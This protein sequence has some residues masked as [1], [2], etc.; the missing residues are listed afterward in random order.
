MCALVPSVAYLETIFWAALLLGAPTL[1]L[2]D[3]GPRASPAVLAGHRPLPGA[4]AA[5]TPATPR[6]A[7]PGPWRTHEPQTLG[8]LGRMDG[9]PHGS[10]PLRR[11]GN[12]GNGARQRA[13]GRDP[14]HRA[15]DVLGERRGGR[16]AQDAGRRAGLSSACSPPW[17]SPRIRLSIHRISE[18]PRGN[19]VAILHPRPGTGGG[20]SEGPSLRGSSESRVAP[21]IAPRGS[22]RSGRARFTHPALRFTGSLHVEGA[23][24]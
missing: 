6:R 21:G 17:S 3:E 8:A 5:R 22:H 14:D 16:A 10:P 4:E 24:A 7:F 18:D 9:V 1:T 2:P 19:D 15:R 20:V 11:A 13:R 23:D 12:G